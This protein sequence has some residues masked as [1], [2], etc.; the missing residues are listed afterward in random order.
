MLQKGFTL[1][2]LMIVVAII[3]I[4]SMFALPAYQ[5]YTKRTYVSEGI[6]LASAAKMATTEAFSTT[7]IWPKDNKEA[8]LPAP[9]KISGQSVAGIALAPGGTSVK[10]TEI[11]IYFNAKVA[12]EKVS[13][14]PATDVAPGVPAA[15]GTLTLIPTNFETAGAVKWECKGTK[16]ITADKNGLEPKWLPTNCRDK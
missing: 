7:G 4:L 2:E 12:G 3:G 11:V 16:G 6:A 15:A 8:G 14:V 9:E 5:D 10:P 1:I 13:K